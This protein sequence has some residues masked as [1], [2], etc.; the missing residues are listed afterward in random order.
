MSPF[1][2]SGLV[3]WKLIPFAILR[4][5]WKERNTRVF[6]GVSM[7][8]EYEFSLVFVCIA[9]WASMREDF[10]RLKVEGIIH[11]LEGS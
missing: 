11:N 10:D 7:P 2:G 6:K 5:I 8:V 9:K 1:I 3:L 4:S